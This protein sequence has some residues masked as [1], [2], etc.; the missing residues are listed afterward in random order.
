MPINF[1]NSPS[2][3]Q[4]YTSGAKTWY[5]TGSAWKVK[6]GSL[7]TLTIGSGLSGTSYDG[8][9][10]TTIA[11]ASNP[12]ISV[13]GVYDGFV[14]V[15][16][17]ATT[18]HSSTGGTWTQGTNPAGNSWAL[19]YGNDKWVTVNAFGTTA[20]YSTDG[21]TWTTSTLPSNS[22]WD[23]IAFGNGYFVAVSYQ[24]VGVARSTDGITWTAGPTYPT[25]P[26]QFG[27]LRVNI[28][29]GANGFIVTRT[30][31]QN[32]GLST[33]GL[34][35]TTFTQIQTFS[36]GYGSSAYGA[37][38]YLVLPLESNFSRAMY[39]TDGITWT[40][41]AL[42]I[43]ATWTGV[44]YANGK[45]VALNKNSR[46][47]LYSTDAVTWTFSVMPVSDAWYRVAYGN[48][49]F[50]AIT[51]TA[52]STVAAISED[53]INWISYSV[54][55]AGPATSYTD[56]TFGSY[57]A[58]NSITPT[59]LSYLNTLTSSIQA[60]LDNKPSIAS[61]SNYLTTVSASSTYLPLTGGVIAGN[62]TANSFIKTGGTSS[63]YLMADGSTITGVPL[64]EITPIDDISNYF[65]GT[66]NRFVP[67]YQGQQVT[68]SNP[69]RL[70]LS[71]NGIIQRVSNAEYVWQSMIAQNGV[72]V[73]ND[74]YIVFPEAVPA[75]SQFDAR[76]M[77]GSTTTST[78]T[79]YPFKAL[80]I[81]LGG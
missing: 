4:E 29:Y 26:W 77:A 30:P 22:G 1:P 32:G 56:I 69:F 67:R 6:I 40:G 38:R 39:S 24:N 76:L 12:T 46:N 42:P 51:D 2:L 64:P 27:N 65:D 50:I 59:K 48:G 10:A 68:I 8:S 74:G 18:S 17:G 36:N 7:S 55:G 34:T 13:T 73:D 28:T 43:N 25:F 37:G 81:I 78:T 58:T 3:N 75:G 63:Q 41:Y 62:L 15:T 35:W 45:F 44:V 20:A 33:D 11:L 9:A 19:T 49:K 14:A 16:N 5:W 70:L 52:N 79:T 71:I 57:S 66:T 53:G 60:Q 80:D 61:L 21:I 31:G 72:R 47:V 23:D 54:P